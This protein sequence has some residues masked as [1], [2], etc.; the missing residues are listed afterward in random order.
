MLDDCILQL[1]LVLDGSVVYFQ[2]LVI[3]VFHLDLNI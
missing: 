2:Q 1:V 3:L